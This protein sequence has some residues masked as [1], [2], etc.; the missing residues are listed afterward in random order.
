MDMRLRLPELLSERSLT[1]YAVARDSGGRINESTL[2]RLVRAEGRVDLFSAELCQA[3]CEVLKIGPAELF[4]LEDAPSTGG[5]LASPRKRA[6]VTR[7]GRG[8]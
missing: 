2:Y 3:L 4:Q 7:K 5:T 8:T 6:P 1:P